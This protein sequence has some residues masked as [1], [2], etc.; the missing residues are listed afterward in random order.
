MSFNPP[1]AFGRPAFGREDEMSLKLTLASEKDT[2]PDPHQTASALVRMAE[3]LFPAKHTITDT[4]QR[5]GFLPWCKLYETNAYVETASQIAATPA[6][7]YGLV[8]RSQ[9]VVGLLAREY[10]KES[11]GRYT[12]SAFNSVSNRQNHS[13][14]SG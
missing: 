6:S 7:L 5:G 2:A 14:T 9:Q 13:A 8:R 3:G 12:L 4:P 1:H 10:S 11:D